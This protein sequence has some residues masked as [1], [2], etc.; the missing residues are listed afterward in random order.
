MWTA[1]H[2]QGIL[3]THF[4]AKIINAALR[5]GKKLGILEK[6]LKTDLT[7]SSCYLGIQNIN[8]CPKIDEKCS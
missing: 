6:D 3:S 7:S 5:D 1:P 4:H 8:S 2:E